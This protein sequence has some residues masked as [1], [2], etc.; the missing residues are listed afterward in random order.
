MINIAI[1]G[2]PN[3]GKSTFFN[4]LVGR[5]QA[6]THD[7]PGVTRDRRISRGQIADL[8]FNL[9]DTAG[10]EL[11]TETNLKKSMVKQTKIALTECQLVLFMVDAIDGLT[12]EDREI[13]KLVRKENKPILLVVNKCENMRRAQNVDDFYKLGFEHV[14][15]LSAEHGD[16]MADFYDAILPFFQQI[17]PQEKDE[18]EEGQAI[19][20]AIIGRPNAGKST[21]I[22]ALL[23]E[24]RVIT[25]EEAGLTRDAISIRWNFEG[26]KVKLTDTAG[27]RRR[28]NVV[29]TLE[30]LSNAD[31]IRAL[32]F[33]KIVIILTTPDSF[34]EQQDLSIIDLVI[35]EGR[36]P[37]I[38]VNKWD[39][40]KKKKELKEEI[41]EK[42]RK[43]LTDIQNVP[44]ICISALKKQNLEFLLKHSIE[45]LK[46]WEKKISTSKLNEW[47]KFALEEHQPPLVSAANSSKKRRLK[48]KYLTQN[49]IKPP[50][51]VLFC[52]LPDEVPQS[53]MRYLTKSLR[54]NFGLDGVPI[55]FSLKASENPY[56]KK[57]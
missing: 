24:E 25:G 46:I 9:V 30:T 5:K 36:L 37:I 17:E 45:S 55:R 21:L 29:S 16:G 49:K 18:N 50:S 26:H 4:R 54:E 47:L 53:Y 20:I 10:Y 41:E 32:K 8:E 56:A 44:V 22:N 28:K 31:S 34:G 3:V 27:L 13:S 43:S 15:H 52:N 6:I 38:A 57:I 7:L 42:V 2:R 14:V 33:A 23:N 51:F 19:E 48:F 35:K 12:E 39:L 11:Q 40:V 1:I